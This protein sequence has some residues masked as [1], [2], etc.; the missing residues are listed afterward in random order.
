MVVAPSD[1]LVRNLELLRSELK[2]N[3]KGDFAKYVDGLRKPLAKG[4]TLTLTAADHEKLEEIQISLRGAEFGRR[5]DVLAAGAEKVGH[6]DALVADLNRIA[7]QASAA[8]FGTDA[9]YVQSLA[10]KLAKGSLELKPKDHKR[11]EYIYSGL[12]VHR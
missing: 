5:K 2:S 4:D 8:G 12:A 6:S 3:R 9:K 11:L 7:Q 10:A 1:D